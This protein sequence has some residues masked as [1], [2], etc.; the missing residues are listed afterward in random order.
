MLESG[1]GNKVLKRKLNIGIYRR[2]FKGADRRRIAYLRSLT[3]KFP[4]RIAA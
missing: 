2:Q 4:G 3:A 1:N